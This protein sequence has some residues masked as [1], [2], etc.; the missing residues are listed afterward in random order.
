MRLNNEAWAEIWTRVSD[1]V[2]KEA[3]MVV[4]FDDDD[5]NNTNLENIK[6]FKGPMD[7]AKY[8]RGE[9]VVPVFDGNDPK[10]KEH[11]ASKK[12]CVS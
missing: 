11:Y 3:G 9:A 6:I 5:E 8:H 2:P 10:M 4:H 7:H 12:S 1:V